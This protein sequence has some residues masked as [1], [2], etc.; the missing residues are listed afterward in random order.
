MNPETVMRADK[1]LTVRLP[2]D[3]H[4]DLTQLAK[5]TG[6]TKSF[7]AVQALTVYVET[8]AWQIRDIEQELAEADR[9]EFATPE[10][11]NAFFRAYAD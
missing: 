11:V 6:R 1:T 3:L 2:V 4:D 9:G 10:E 5:M 7:L 8:E